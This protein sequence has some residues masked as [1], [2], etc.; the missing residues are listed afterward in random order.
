[1]PYVNG[2]Y[3]LPER[4][5]SAIPDPLYMAHV[6]LCTYLWNVLAYRHDRD[7]HSAARWHRRA[8]ETADHLRTM[9]VR[10]RRRAPSVMR[11]GRPRETSLRIWLGRRTGEQG[12]AS[13]RASAEAK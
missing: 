11:H 4:T 2:T 5:P 1:M 8:W 9:L 12:G 6:R 7:E 3:R 10:P 13:S